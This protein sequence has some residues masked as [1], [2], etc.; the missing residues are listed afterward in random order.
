[1][2]NKKQLNLDVV[3][4]VK[5]LMAL[6]VVAIHTLPPATFPKGISRCVSAVYALAVPFFFVAS[7]FFLGYKVSEKIQAEKL[8]Y[9]RI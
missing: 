7:G 5:L 1:M 6:V 2:K 8:A 3:D 9:I 4:C